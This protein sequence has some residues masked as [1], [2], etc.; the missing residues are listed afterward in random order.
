MVKN[1][2][3]CIRYYYTFKLKGEEEGDASISFVHSMQD[4]TLRILGMKIKMKL[5]MLLLVKS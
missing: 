4:I 3:T 2:V 5:S 1:G